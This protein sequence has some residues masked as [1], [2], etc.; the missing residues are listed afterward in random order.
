MKNKGIFLSFASLMVLG[1]AGSIGYASWQY[2][3]SEKTISNI[4]LNIKKWDFSW[5]GSDVLDDITYE[6]ASEFPTALNGLEDP[7]S[8]EGQA[9]AQAIAAKKSTD[10][11]GNMD[12][13][14]N[15]SGNLAKVLNVSD[16]CTYIIKIKAD[17]SYEL[18][19]TYVDYSKKSIYARFGPVYK[20]VYK[21]DEDGN[22]KAV[23][24]YK[25]TATVTYYDA[26]HGQKQKSFNTDDF[27]SY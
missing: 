8:V 22:Y 23:Q 11:V 17:G 21:Q 9:L 2:S 25:G 10:W 7:D 14:V 3:K 20:T 6:H 27:Q 19:M 18:Y 12:S 5:T 26:A 16:D 13:I 24:S 15:V 1:L 4:A